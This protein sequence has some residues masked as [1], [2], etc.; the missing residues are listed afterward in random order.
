MITVIHGFSWSFSYFS[1]MLSVQETDFTGL[2]QIA[3]FLWL[4]LRFSSELVGVNKWRPWKQ[5]E[6]KRE[7]LFFGSLPAFQGWLSS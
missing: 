5:E 4:P 6:R 3:P 7:Y 1:I 2:R